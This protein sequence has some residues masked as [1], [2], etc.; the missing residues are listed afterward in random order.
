MIKPIITAN[1]AI[2]AKTITVSPAYFTSRRNEN[3]QGATTDPIKAPTPTFPEQ[4]D[5]NGKLNIKFTGERQY[6]LNG[7]KIDYFA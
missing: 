7:N 4:N 6:S 1:Q 5:E 2:A 3:T